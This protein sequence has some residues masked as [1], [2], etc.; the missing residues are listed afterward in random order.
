MAVQSAP[1]R[2]RKP[3]AAS[4]RAAAP[5]AATQPRRAAALKSRRAVSPFL[6]LTKLRAGA[7]GEWQEWAELGIFDDPFKILLR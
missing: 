3:A 1:P 7:A 2:H 5:P 4:R 6:M